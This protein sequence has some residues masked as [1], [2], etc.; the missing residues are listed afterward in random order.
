MAQS[1]VCLNFKETAKLF[2]KLG[3][4]LLHTYQQCVRVPISFSCALSNPYFLVKCLFK[5]FAHLRFFLQIEFEI[6]FG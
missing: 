3:T 2:L 5:Y 1:C 6:S 4:V